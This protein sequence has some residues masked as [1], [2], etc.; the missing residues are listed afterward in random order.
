MKKYGWQLKDKIRRTLLLLISTTLLL[1]SAVYAGNWADSGCGYRLKLTFN[2]SAAAQPLSNFPALVKLNSGRIDYASTSDTD[3]RFYDGANLLPK[4]TEVWNESGESFVW[5][6]VPAVENTNTD[7]IFAYYDCANSSADNPE[8]VWD[9][10][11]VMVH[12]L[13]ETSGNHFDSTS[14][15]N[16][17][18]PGGGDLLKVPQQNSAGVAGKADLF[19]GV[20]DCVVVSHNNSL[21]FGTGAFTISAW[22]KYAP[23]PA[24]S[25]P[26][27][28]RKGNQSPAPGTAPEANYKMELLDN[29]LSA[30]LQGTNPGGGGTVTAPTATSDN[31]WHN[32][33]FLR[34]GTTIYLYVDGEQKASTPGA[35]INLTNTATMGIGSKDGCADDHFAGTIDELQISRVARSADWIR[36]SNLATRDQFIVYGTT[37]CYGDFDADGEADGMDLKDFIDQ[38]IAGTAV[39][40]DVQLFAGAFGRSCL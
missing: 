9:A 30:T 19:D 5:V 2:N 17:G 32:A 3:I 18:V 14:Y 6:K 8:A 36:A 1:P 39:A 37:N 31:A 4:E 28:L 38:L 10:N 23:A 33:V 11:F 12:H 21:N 13:A 22:V 27:I 29:K 7:Y 35:G 15:N 24:N 34:N 25:D 26:D 40:A 16:D 20:N